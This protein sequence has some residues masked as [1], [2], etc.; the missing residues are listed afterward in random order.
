MTKS[1]K[2]RLRDAR[3]SLMLAQAQLERAQV[4]WWEPSDPADCVTNAFYDYENAVTAAM[5]ARG[6]KRTHRHPEKVAMA[7]E[8]Y[9]E[10]LLKT[11]VSSLLQT[12]NDARKDVQYGE[13]G[14]QLRQIHLES[15]VS[16]LEEFTDEVEAMLNELDED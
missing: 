14:Y 16:D 5:L 2:Q 15:L 7:R 13:P 3:A 6:R 1:K 4:A 8:L 10:N 12:L 9:E 11:D